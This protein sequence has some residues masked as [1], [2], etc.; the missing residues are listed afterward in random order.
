[1]FARA[2]HGSSDFHVPRVPCGGGGS[3]RVLVVAADLTP[4]SQEAMA[5]VPQWF[6]HIFTSTN[7]LLLG[8]SEET[9]NLS[10]NVAN[11]HK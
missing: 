7:S 10:Q 2:P 6:L 11:A 3:Y 8:R 4:T 9:R 5:V 1:M